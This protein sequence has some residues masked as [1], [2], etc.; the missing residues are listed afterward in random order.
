MQDLTPEA[1]R[2]LEEIAGRHGVSRDAALTLLRALAVGG[3]TM[4]Q[5]SHPELGGMGQWSQGGMV[6]VGDL[7]NQDLKYRVDA[8]CNDLSALLRE[9]APLTGGGSSQF[10]SQ[11][12]GGPGQGFS[13]GNW[14]PA[15]LGSPASSGAQNDMRYAYFPASR[16]LAVQQGR[17]L[18]VYD[19]GSHRIF[20]VSQQQGAGRTLT[21]S[22]DQGTVQL[23]DL[24]SVDS[25]ARAASQPARPT[26]G[27]Y[28]PPAAAAAAPPMQPATV[29]P[30]P[31]G[32]DP[33]AIIERLAEL[34]RRGILTEEEFAAKKAE[35]LSR[36]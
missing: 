27:G 20:G 23:T 29:A 35:L 10:Q 6:M 16:R 19:T 8:L 1:G 4:A 34:Q 15:E 17:Q 13:S 22:S 2:S 33:L 28:N 7:F 18:R 9:L 21:F 14:W 30:A 25:P 11:R 5:F 31:P 12:P 3:G 36:L 32:D 24:R 26:P